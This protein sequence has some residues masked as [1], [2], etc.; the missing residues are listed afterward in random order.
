ME[1]ITMGKEGRRQESRMSATTVTSKGQVTIPKAIRD[2]LGVG[3]GDRVSFIRAQDGQVVVQAETVDFRTLR[4]VFK[5][6]GP[7]VSLEEMDEAI[8]EG[9]LASGRP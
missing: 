3:P 8:A 9:A 4:G 1:G 2:L 6:K 7:T 5:H